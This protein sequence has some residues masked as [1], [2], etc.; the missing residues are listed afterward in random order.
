MFASLLATGIGAALGTRPLG[1]RR[2]IDGSVY[3][4][5]KSIVAIHVAESRSVAEFGTF[6]NLADLGPGRRSLISSELARGDSGLYRLTLRL[7]A[8]GYSIKATP[9]QSCKSCPE[10][11][12]DETMRIV[13]ASRGAEQA[14]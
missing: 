1:E 7:T 12:S 11:Y 9:K 5:Y 4:A 10:L 13:S 14:N 2:E 3:H 6:A 8:S